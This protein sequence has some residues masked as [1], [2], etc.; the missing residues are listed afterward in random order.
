M[1]ETPQPMKKI[2]Y[3]IIEGIAFMHV[4]INPPCA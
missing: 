2:K 4:K 3:V 1:E